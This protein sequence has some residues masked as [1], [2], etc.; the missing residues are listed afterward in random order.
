MWQDSYDS[1]QANLEFLMDPWLSMQWHQQHWAQH[2]ASHWMDAGYGVGSSS[3]TDTAVQP[4]ET[5]N[6]EQDTI[7]RLEK[8]KEDLELA[9]W[10]KLQNALNIAMQNEFATE[11]ST[12]IERAIFFSTTRGRILPHVVQSMPCVKQLR[13]SRCVVRVGHCTQSWTLLQR[14]YATH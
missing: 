9:A 14:R 7:A 13:R 8:I 12:C 4:L 5:R 11:L 10:T 6:N 3:S 2:W 1:Y